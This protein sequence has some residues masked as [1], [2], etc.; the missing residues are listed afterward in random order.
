MDT[1]LRSYMDE[2]GF[3]PIALV[4][5]YQNVS[6]YGL[7]MEEFLAKFQSQ[8]FATLEVDLENEKLKRKE[9]W[10]MVSND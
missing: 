1:F 6:C 10:E 7:A 4:C 2:D 5:S 3:V 9:K 8:E